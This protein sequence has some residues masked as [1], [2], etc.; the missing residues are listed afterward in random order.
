[1]TSVKCHFAP[2]PSSSFCVVVNLFCFSVDKLHLGGFNF[3]PPQFICFFQ[4]ATS[5][6]KKI[7]PC[8]ACST[9]LS[10]MPLAGR[11]QAFEK[12]LTS[13]SSLPRSILDN[14][15]TNIRIAAEATYK[16]DIIPETDTNEG[17]LALYV[18]VANGF[19]TTS[20]DNLK[21]SHQEGH[22]HP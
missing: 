11:Q 13:W 4:M 22:P 21:V 8:G 12:R 6:F 19:R 17:L 5:P 16:D 7:D 10:A 2:S 3:L 9:Y 20:T 15:A 14:A 1:M 18:Y